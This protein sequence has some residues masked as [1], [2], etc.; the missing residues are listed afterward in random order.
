MLKNEAPFHFQLLHNVIQ[1][2]C[3][4]FFTGVHCSDVVLML[5]K[6]PFYASLREGKQKFFIVI[7]LRCYYQIKSLYL[8]L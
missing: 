1:T 7:L 5:A 3:I 6:P 4:Y 2:F 8:I